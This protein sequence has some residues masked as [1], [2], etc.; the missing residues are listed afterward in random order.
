MPFEAL[1]SILVPLFVLKEAAAE[2]AHNPYKLVLLEGVPILT[3]LSDSSHHVH[4][5]LLIDRSSVQ[6]IFDVIILFHR[7]EG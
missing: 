4:H 6:I 3:S 7:S 2:S 5:I 1:Q